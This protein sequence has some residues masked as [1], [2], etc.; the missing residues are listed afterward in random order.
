[1]KPVTL[2]AA[3]TDVARQ[4]NHFRNRRLAAVEARVEARDLRHAREPLR[5]CLDRSEIVGL[6][7]RGQRDERSEFGKY[8]RRDDRRTDVRGPPWTT[9]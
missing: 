7:Q 6:V 5:R 4:R 1:M 9:R 3:A 2:H 8:F